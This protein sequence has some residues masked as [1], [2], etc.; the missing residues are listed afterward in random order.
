MG[1]A[2]P[3]PASPADQSSSGG[4]GPRRSARAAPSAARA[5]GG[6]RRGPL[7][8]HDRAA[9]RGKVAG[10]QPFAVDPAAAIGGGGPGGGAG[11]QRLRPARLGA[12]RRQ[13]VSRPP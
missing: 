13:A 6:G 11:R 2:A 12:A 5:R 8:P 9:W 10:G 4:A 7:P 3:T 1:P